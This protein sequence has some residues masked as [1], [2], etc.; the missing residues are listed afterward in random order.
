MPQNSG[1]KLDGLIKGF[2]LFL[3]VTGISIALIEIDIPI[4]SEI[5]RAVLLVMSFGVFLFGISKI[6]EPFRV[7]LS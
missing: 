7:V 3:F 6:I 2:S 4:I 1:F 5:P